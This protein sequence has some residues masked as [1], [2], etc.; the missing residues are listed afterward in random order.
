MSQSAPGG[1]AGSPHDHAGKGAGKTGAKH[2][3]MRMGM[4]MMMG[5]GMMMMAPAAM[6]G[7][8]MMMRPAPMMGAGMMMPGPMMGA[9]MMGPGAAMMGPAT[10]A[11]SCQTVAV[12]PG[13]ALSPDDVRASLERS[14]TWHGNTR[15]KVGEVK[16]ADNG[17]IVAEIVTVD[18]SLVQRLAVDRQTGQMR[19]VD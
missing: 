3:H 7:P 17:T 4:G 8:G 15:L 11:K 14:L 5:P 12:E 6:M 16:E 9:G 2:G 13:K 19:R 1:A 10:A 18:D